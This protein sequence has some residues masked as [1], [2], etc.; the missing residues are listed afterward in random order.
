MPSRRERTRTV[1]LLLNSVDRLGRT[2]EPSVLSV[3]QEI[4]A[5]AVAQGEKLLGDPALAVSLFEEVAATVSKTISDKTVANE[6]RIKNLAGYLF[7]AYMRRIRKEERKES[8]FRVSLE[9]WMGRDTQESDHLDV[10]QHILVDELLSAC[11]GLTRA[12]I[13]LRARGVPYKD[14][15]ASFGISAAAARQ[16]YSAAIR[17]IRKILKER[18]R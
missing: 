9:E 7:T 5:R 8:A 11:D 3:A 14:V 1:V 15:E 10:E 4:A 17:Q 12:I 16:R 13:L 6:P 18:P 2:V